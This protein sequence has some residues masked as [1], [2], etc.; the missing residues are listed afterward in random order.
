MG[1]LHTFYI[2]HPIE[3]TTLL[4]HPSNVSTHTS[5]GPA[6]SLYFRTFQM[7]HLIC[8]SIIGCNKSQ[9]YTAFILK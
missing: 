1:L 9:Q 3:E 6:I 8:V 2:S 4:F 5:G 7:L